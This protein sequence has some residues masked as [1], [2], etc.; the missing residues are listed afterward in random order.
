MKNL[1]ERI[2]SGETVLGSWL[3]LGSHVS[4]DIMGHAGFDWLLIDMEHGS[5][6]EDMMFHQL[7]VLAAMN[8][9]WPKL[10]V[11]HILVKPL[12]SISN[13]WIKH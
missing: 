6:Y 13:S 1:K 12:K 11:P 4:A 2:Q 5:G 9:A 8:V 3:N 10:L 7:Q